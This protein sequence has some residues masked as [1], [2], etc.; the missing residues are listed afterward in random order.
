MIPANTDYQHEISKLMKQLETTHNANAMLRI[1]DQ[2]ERLESL[3]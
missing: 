3:S 1:F 2:I